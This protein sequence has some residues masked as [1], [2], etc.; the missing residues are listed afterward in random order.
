VYDEATGL[1]K[2]KQDA[3]AKGASYT[4]DEMG[5][6]RSR[7]WARGVATTYSYAVNTGELTGVDYA[8]TTPD[9]SLAYDRGGRQQTITDAA[10]THTR[11][12]TERGDLKT[13]HISGGLLDM[14]QVATTY[15]SLLRRQFLQASRGGAVL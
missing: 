11:S 12:F 9:V 2:Q 5:R 13:E 4:Y 10:G 14:V 6:V 8:D 1:V 3:A 15:D 7:A